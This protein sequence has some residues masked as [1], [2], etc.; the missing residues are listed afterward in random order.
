MN[1]V[2]EFYTDHLGRERRLNSGPSAGNKLSVVK[3]WS[4]S[5]N[6]IIPKETWFDITR[7]DLFE[8]ED[9]IF[10]VK[11]TG[12]SAACIFAG[13]IRTARALAGCMDVKLSPGCLQVQGNMT[14]TPFTDFSDI[15][16]ISNCI[17]TLPFS[18]F[19]DVGFF[20]SDLPNNWLEKAL[21]YKF[22]RLYRCTS[23]EDLVSGLLCGGI[24]VYNYR[25]GMCYEKFDQYGVAGHDYGDSNHCGYA[26]GLT[27]LSDGRWVLDTVNCFSHKWG[28]FNNGRCYIDEHH[29]FGKDGI[30]DV[31]V[32]F[33][34]YQVT[35][36]QNDIP[37]A[38]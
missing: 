10:E 38:G 15:T 22:D 24:A 27:R 36:Q 11:E 9:W 30:P 19:G 17:G 26:D 32:G 23:F 37:K 8:D 35:Q 16:N 33:V 7:R 1:N 25:V 13:A 29:L 14:S 20:L 4:K 18:D 34:N 2:V 31:V 3:E 12:S 5:G 6:A 28:P 21:N